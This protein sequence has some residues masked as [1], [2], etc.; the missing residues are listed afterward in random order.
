M[1]VATKCFYILFYNNSFGKSLFYILNQNFKVVL[2]RTP[3][4]HLT[5]PVLSKIKN[6]YFTGLSVNTFLLTLASFFSDVSTEMLYPILPIYLTMYVGLSGGILGLIEGIATA[7]QN[8]IQGFSGYLSDKWQRK[9]RVALFGYCLSAVSK[10][11]IGIS[12]SWPGI[13]S[14][15]FT[16]RLGSG[17]R[18]APR[19]ALVA[20]S[21]DEKN[22]GKAFGLEG[23]GDNAGAFLGPVITLLLFFYFAFEIRSIFFIAFI[24]GLLAVIMI[25][26]VKDEKRVTTNTKKTSFIYTMRELPGSYWKYIFVTILFGLGNSSNLFLILMVKEKGLTL[27]MTV[28]IYALFN[29]VAALFSY[30]AGNWSDKFGR[31]PLLLVA[32]VIYFITYLGFGISNDIYVFGI[33]FIFYG[34]FQ[35]AFRAVGKT[36][37]TDFAPKELRASAVG[38]YSTAVGL[39]G[40][41][42]SILAGQLWDRVSH[43]SVFYTGAAFSLAGIVAL[44]FLLPGKKTNSIAS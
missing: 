42:A 43:T 5:D 6:K 7:T 38:W 24:P 13:L 3:S 30:P 26:F 44:V 11:L 2:N 21:A 8:I 23:L 35:G 22:R 19:D 41:I 28:G 1:N 25:L 9:K 40:L 4:S 36:F 15:R 10:P 12:N 27:V 32:F 29:L 16:D 34:L 31:K 39:S 18:S 17:I 14:A 37:A 20:A 33:L